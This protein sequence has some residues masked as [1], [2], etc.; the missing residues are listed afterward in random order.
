[1]TNKYDVSIIRMVIIIV[2]RSVIQKYEYREFFKS[3]ACIAIHEYAYI[4]TYM[5][6]LRI[7]IHIS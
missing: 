1:M 6:I 7:H 4:C 3:N 5:Y 2:L